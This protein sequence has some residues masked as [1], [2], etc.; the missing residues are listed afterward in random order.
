MN[1]IIARLARQPNELLQFSHNGQ[2]KGLLAD[3][4]IE[5]QLTSPPPSQQETIQAAHFTEHPTHYIL[6]ARYLGYKHPM[7]NGYLAWC[8]PKKKY[9]LEQ[10]VEFSKRL[11]SSPV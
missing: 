9:S 6:V 8:L 11:L 10:F 4:N 5:N 2:I 3:L 7:D 1:K